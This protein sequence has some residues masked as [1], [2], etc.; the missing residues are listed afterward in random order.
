MRRASIAATICHH[1]RTLL[2]RQLTN[3]SPAW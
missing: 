3:R 1:L 2:D